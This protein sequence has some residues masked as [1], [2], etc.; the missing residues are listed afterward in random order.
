[1]KLILFYLSL[2]VISFSSCSKD[3]DAKSTSQINSN[4]QSGTWR[5]TRYIDSEV[6]ETIKF[7]SYNFTFQSN[8]IVYATKGN[9]TYTGSWSITDSN[10]DDDS[11]EDLDFNL[12]FGLIN[13]FEDLNDDWDFISQSA[14]KIELIDVSGGSGE[15]DYLSFE[16]N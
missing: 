8:G 13:D 4:V 12:Y 1:M 16:K 9:V 10:S 2:I 11:Q 7:S 6:D 14:S 15:T 5:I 3:D